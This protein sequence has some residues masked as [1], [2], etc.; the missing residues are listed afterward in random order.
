MKSSRFYSISNNIAPANDAQIQK[1][2]WQL[3]RSVYDPVS[4]LKERV[5]IEFIYKGRRRTTGIKPHHFSPIKFIQQRSSTGQTFFK[6]CCQTNNLQR[7]LH[8]NKKDSR[9]RARQFLTEIRNTSIEDVKRKRATKSDVY[10]YN[11][12]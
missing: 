7:N 12:E 3:D 10:C 9:K 4:W 5:W 11:S 2:F 8:R 6:Y 1:D